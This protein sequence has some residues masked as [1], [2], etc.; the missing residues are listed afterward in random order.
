MKKKT[1]III[2]DHAYDRARKRLKWSSSTLNRMINRIYYEGI[3]S[4]NSKG[5]LKIYFE[6]LNNRNSQCNNIRIFG[7][8]VFFF[9]NNRLITMLPL[10]LEIKNYIQSLNKNKK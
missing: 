10:P 2:T 1:K 5:T 9:M 8:S 6:K 4:K 7:N 3:S